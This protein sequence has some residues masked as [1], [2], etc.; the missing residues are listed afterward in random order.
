MTIDFTR[1]DLIALLEIIEIF[2]QDYEKL[3]GDIAIEDKIRAALEE[4]TE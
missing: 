1:A 3:A 2:A 4:T